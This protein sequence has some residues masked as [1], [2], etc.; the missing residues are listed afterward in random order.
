M[1]ANEQPKKWKCIN[2]NKEF[3]VGEWACS[4]GIS[5]HVVEE[6]TYRVLDA[7]SDAGKPAEGTLMPIVRGRTTVCNIPPPKKVMEGGEVR[8]IGEG[9]VEF[10]N[11]RFST[12]DPEIQY[13]LDKKPAYQATEDQWKATWLSKDEQL[14][15]K[16]IALRAV[17]RR[18][19][20]ERNE[21]L[22]QV[23]QKTR[24]PVGTNG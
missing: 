15:E 18:L 12:S 4:D 17:E 8:Q 10:I 11:G 6:K 14:A 13:W 23:K 7:P 22:A 16:E 9:S 24:T 2:C 1:A 21:L 3:M 20:N 5:N 19:E